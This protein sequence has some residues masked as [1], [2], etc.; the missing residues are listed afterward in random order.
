MDDTEKKERKGF[1]AFLKEKEK[2][3]MKMNKLRNSNDY[4]LCL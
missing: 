3:I 4:L 1:I 2:K